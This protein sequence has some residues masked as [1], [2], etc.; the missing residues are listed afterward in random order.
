MILIGK[1]GSGKTTL[2]QRVES[3]AIEYQKTQ[4]II[5][6]DFFI[7][8]PGE[9]V[10]MRSLYR[11]LIV[12]AADADVIGLMQGCDDDEYRLPPQFSSILPKEFVGIVSKTDLAADGDRAGIERVRDMMEIAGAVRIFELSALTGQGIDEFVRY[13]S[14]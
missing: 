10:E 5:Y 4:M 1:S 2:I 9:Y 7:D 13:L 14:D 6:T 3:T 12:T 8:T 11:A